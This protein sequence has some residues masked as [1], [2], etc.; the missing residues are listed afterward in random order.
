MPDILKTAALPDARTRGSGVAVAAWSAGDRE[1]RISIRQSRGAAV[2]ELVALEM[3]PDVFRGVESGGIAGE[4]LDLDGSIEGF[5]IFARRCAAMRSQAVP[6]HEQEVADLSAQSVQ[7]L[8]DLRT[9]D[10]SR[11]EPEVEA[12]RGAASDD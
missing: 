8:D 12:S 6:D 9:L 11:K 7:E 10:H 3:A 4:L 5:E 1:R 2:D